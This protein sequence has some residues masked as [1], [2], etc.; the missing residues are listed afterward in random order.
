MQ[1]RLGSHDRSRLWLNG[2]FHTRYLARRSDLRTANAGW[3]LSLALHALHLAHFTAL[4]PFL[5]GEGWRPIVPTHLGSRYFPA[6]RCARGHGVLGTRGITRPDRLRHTRVFRLTRLPLLILHFAHIAPLLAF[7]RRDGR[8]GTFVATQFGRDA[9]VIGAA[10]LLA[11]EKFAARLAGGV[12]RAQAPRPVF[13][14][15]IRR[16]ATV[17][18]ARGLGCV[19]RRAATAIGTWHAVRIA[20]AVEISATLTLPATFAVVR[21]QCGWRGR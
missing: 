20:L 21:A 3:W 5:R 9:A 13:L 4:F 12:L 10:L 1:R 17:F 19:F 2:T 11:A 14:R 8:R 18:T 16:A 6:N 7:L 15:G